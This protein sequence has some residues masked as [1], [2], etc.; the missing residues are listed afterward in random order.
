M[1]N[2]HIHFRFNDD[3]TLD[4]VLLKFPMPIEKMANS[5]DIQEENY[6]TVMISVDGLEALHEYFDEC[7]QNPHEDLVDFL[8][9]L[10]DLGYQNLTRVI[11]ELESRDT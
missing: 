9:F 4:H 6:K 3:N 1:D 8:E 7:G 11:K 10:V 5:S 2:K